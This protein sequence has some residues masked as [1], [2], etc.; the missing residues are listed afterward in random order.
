MK[1]TTNTAPVELGKS[2]QELQDYR[3]LQLEKELG[4]RFD[5]VMDG[6]HDLKQD[7]KYIEKRFEKEYNDLNHRVEEL[8]HFADERRKLLKKKEENRE[9]TKSYVRNILIASIITQLFSWL[10]IGLGFIPYIFKHFL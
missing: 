10:I 6:L 2:T 5:E 7:T 8:E 4:K 1:P 9:E 3:L